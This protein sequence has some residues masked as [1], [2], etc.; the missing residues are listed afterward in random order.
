MITEHVQEAMLYVKNANDIEPNARLEDLQIIKEIAN[1]CGFKVRTVS[2]PDT[3]KSTTD[4][5]VS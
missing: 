1:K 3:Q 5:I 2:A 4:A